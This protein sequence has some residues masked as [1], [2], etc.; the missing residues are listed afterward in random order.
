MLLLWSTK[1]KGD[2]DIL[3]TITKQQMKPLA[4][5]TYV[6][7]STYAVIREAKVQANQQRGER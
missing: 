6:V 1:W 3:G 5:R 2:L 7:Y 4:I